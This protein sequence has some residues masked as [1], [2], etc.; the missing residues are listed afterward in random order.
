MKKVFII[1]LAVLLVSCIDFKNSLKWRADLDGLKL[2]ELANVSKE[3]YTSMNSYI[4]VG[5]T[6]ITEYKVGE[7]R[8]L[9]LKIRNVS[10]EVKFDFHLKEFNQSIGGEILNGQ[11]L[12]ILYA[13]DVS[14]L[15][16]EVSRIDFYSNLVLKKVKVNDTI[17]NFYVRADKFLIRLNDNKNLT[18]MGYSEYEKISNI[19][20]DV[21]FYKKNNNM[22]V[23]IM[24]SNNSTYPVKE[25]Q[26]SNYLFKNI[27]PLL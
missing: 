1:V 11:D 6:L 8:L 20:F 3:S 17:K 7:F 12:D 27:M 2:S 9:G 15:R 10:D 21:L 4:S 5:D 25:G 18:I 13:T 26:L 19:Y 16:E 14:T 22:Y 24:N 23:F